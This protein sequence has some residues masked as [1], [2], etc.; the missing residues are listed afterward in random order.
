[1]HLRPGSRYR[2]VMRL[3]DFIAQRISANKI[4]SKRRSTVC[5]EIRCIPP[6]PE[7]TGKDGA[8]AD[9]LHFP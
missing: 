8:P 3:I 7:N 5:I 9:W 2:A 4:A 6:L 1:M